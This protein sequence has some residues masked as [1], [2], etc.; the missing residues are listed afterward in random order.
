[1]PYEDMGREVPTESDEGYAAVLI[2]DGNPIGGGIIDTVYDPQDEGE[3]HVLVD[4]YAMGGVDDTEEKAIDEVY[5][6]RNLLACAL[7][8]ATHAPSGWKPDPDAPDEWAIVWIETPTGQVSWHVPRDMAE[9]LA[10]PKKDSGYDDYDREVK[11]NRL[12]RWA[13]GRCWC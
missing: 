1:M 7:A 2:A 4:Q 10:P 3:T 8:Q 9:D 6:D 11:N 12:T 5:E 13:E